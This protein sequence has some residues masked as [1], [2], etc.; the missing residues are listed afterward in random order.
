VVATAIRE[1]PVRRLEVRVGY[2]HQV[3]DP[4]FLSLRLLIDGQELLTWAGSQ[5][6]YIGPWPPSVLDADCELFPADPPHRVMLYSQGTP[7]PAES[8]ITAIIRAGGDQV[9]WGDLHE[10]VVNTGD[11]DEIDLDRHTVTSRALDI[12]DIVFDR[13]QYLAEV[14]RAIA[15]REWESDRWQTAQ[16][17]DHCL[18]SGRLRAETDLFPA[19]AE[20]A[21]HNADLFLVT[22]W[23]D[24][25]REGIVVSL[26]AGPGTPQQRAQQM[27]DMLLAAPI[28]QWHVVRTMERT[29]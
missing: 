23:D 16:L 19:Y 21:D 11:F 29:D 18:R 6:P 3:P 14:H 10:S 20:P 25:Q 15:G 1:Q 9:I 28:S 26:T 22:L 2:P 7:D 4:E 17:L 5:G 12:P 13:Q 24:C 8:T 27:T